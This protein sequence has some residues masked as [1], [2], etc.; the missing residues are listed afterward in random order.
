MN[1]KYTLYAR[2]DPS[3]IEDNTKGNNV[4]GSHPMY[5]MRENSG[6]FH[7]MLFKNS[8]PIDIEIEYKKFGLVTIGGIFHFKFF[9]GDKN[10]ETALKMYH[11]Y[12]GGGY[13]TPPFWAFG[14]H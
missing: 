9:F 11:R 10:P 2:D 8:A 1:G 4:Y 5:L 7:V 3:L 12:L 13:L 6:F 14:F